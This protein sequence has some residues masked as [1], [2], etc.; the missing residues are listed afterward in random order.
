[1]RRHSSLPALAL[2]LCLFI[3]LIKT[4]AQA[5]PPLPIDVVYT[6]DSQSLETRVVDRATGI[7][8]LKG[9]TRLDLANDPTIVPSPD[10]HFLYVFGFIRG[11]EI[12]QLAVYPTDT[13]GVPRNSPVQR[14]D[15]PF[16]PF[17]I[18]PNRRNA[19]NFYYDENALKW[20]FLR[21]PINPRTGLVQPPKVV[22]QESQY[23]PCSQWVPG[24]PGIY[25]FSPSGDQVYE[26]WHCS[27]DEGTNEYYYYTRR[28]D[29]QTG[30]VGDPVLTVGTFGDGGGIT[31]V[32]IT[33]NA[34]LEFDTYDCCSLSVLPLS[35]GSPLF[36]CTAEMLDACGNAFSISVDPEGKNVFFQV[37]Q[38]G[39]V[40]YSGCIFQIGKLLFKEN[41][42]VPTGYSIPLN[43]SLVFSPD[44][45]LVY[46]GGQINAS[47][48]DIYV[49]Y[50]DTG[51]V[52]AGG[53]IYGPDSG[54]A[55][56]P[57]VRR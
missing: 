4:M 12:L 56:V 26:E 1:M 42:V 32:N 6:F 17:S 41:E 2:V 34:I 8:V 19:Y 44:D 22:A 45:A 14:V 27:S 21:F 20:D 47:T 35:G 51:E 40:C 11:G 55:M 53:Q 23:G 39:P 15:F 48:F 49:F 43:A 57:A 52:R 7:P 37:E 31:T 46:A 10:D 3:P 25:G 5:V 38:D 13:N 50:P 18:D 24:A 9:F 29:P 33:P 28:V 36:T 16:S 54:F 30:A